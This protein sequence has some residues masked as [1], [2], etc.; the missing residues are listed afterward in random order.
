MLAALL[1]GLSGC[2]GELTALTAI[3]FGMT[4]GALLIARDQ[5]RL[6]LEHARQL[7]LAIS[8]GEHREIEQQFRKELAL[9]A[10]G[11]AVSA[12]REWIARLQLAGLLVAEWR[13]DEARAIYGDDDGTTVAPHLRALA[14]YGRH[15]LAVL[16]EVPN[17][18]R[19]EA[20]RG[21][22]DRW[23]AALPVAFRRNVVQ[24]WQALEGLCLVR[25]G[26][27]REAVPLLERGIHAVEY[28][29]ALVIYFFH[30]AQAYEHIGERALAVQRYEDAA[31]AFPGTRLASEAKARLLNLGPGH[32]PGFRGMLP[33]PPEAEGTP[34]ILIGEPSSSGKRN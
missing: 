3:A 30:L 10:A 34:S 16:T 28:S 2:L 1:T 6:A 31:G 25:M 33:E 9:V 22:R 13:L 24:A 12:E 5:R 19:L 32:D 8:V 11:E 21:D 14:V 26:E 29:P 20:I 7:R 4:I 23:V 27:S 15:E 17:E 18:Q